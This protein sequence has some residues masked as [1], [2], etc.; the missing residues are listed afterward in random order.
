[1]CLYV[2]AAHVVNYMFCLGASQRKLDDPISLKLNA[3]GLSN[4]AHTFSV[5]H[6]KNYSC[7]LK[8]TVNE[9]HCLTL[10][11]IAPPFVQIEACINYIYTGTPREM[12]RGPGHV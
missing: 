2:C 8:K 4:K 1:M 7:G 10:L 11:Y 9:K 3:F 12:K 6:L 5:I